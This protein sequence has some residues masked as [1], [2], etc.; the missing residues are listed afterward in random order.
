MPRIRHLK[1]AAVLVT[2]YCSMITFHCTGQQP[3]YLDAKQSIDKRVDDLISQMTLE[4]KVGQI[5]MPCVYMLGNDIPAKNISI[6]KHVD[7]TLLGTGP[8]G[9]FFTLANEVLRDG[10]R[11]QADF[12]NDL[13]KKAVETTRLKIPLMQ[14]EEGMHGFMAPGATIFPQGMGLGAAWNP[15]LIQEIYAAIAEE[16]RSVGV[17]QIQ[18]LQVE[19]NRDPRHGRNQHTV[20]EDTYL[21]SRYAE[22]V[23]RG[24]QGDDI[25]ANNKVI[26]GLG[27]FPGQGQGLN[28]TNRG[29][30]DISE[31]T[32]QE[33][34]LP[35]WKAGINAGALAI[36]ATHPAIDGYPNHGSEKNLTKTLREELGFKGVLISEGSNTGTLIYERVIASEKEAGPIVLKAGVDINITTES[37]YHKDMI[38]NVKEGKVSMELLDRAVRRILRLKFMLGLFENPY[39]DP[40]RAVKIVHS[41]KNQDLALR[42]S[43]ESIVL[44]KNDPFYPANQHISTS[45]HPAAEPDARR[46][47]LQR[48][49]PLLPLSKSLKSIAVIGPNADSEINLLGDYIPKKLLNKTTSVLQAIR[50]KVSPSTKVTYV[51]GCEVLNTKTNTIEE[52]KKAAKQ[53]QIAIVVVGE[54]MRTD[55]ESKDCVDL[56]LTGL[57][58]ELVEAVYETGTPTVVV[59]NSGRPLTIH[60]IT[61][62][63]P[64]IVETWMCGEKGAEAIADVLFGD[65]NPSG[66][67]PITF[68]RHVGQMPFYYNYKPSKYMRREYAYVTMPLSPLYPF[69]HGLS[70]TTFEYSNLKITPK[71][72]GPGAYFQVSLDVK[73]TGAQEGKEV[74]QL[75]IDD[76][77][78]SMVTPIIELKGFE[79]VNLKP[80]EKKSVNFT[81]IPEQLSLL[82]AHMER[83]VEPGAFKVMV[84]S[85]CEDIR[86]EGEFNVIKN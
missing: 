27:C 49:K 24:A 2:V 31:R 61:E 16:A 79:K 81:L 82:D 67:L 40:E 75:Y 64:A 20:S 39:V 43:Q 30:M 69:G 78:S 33:V 12:F 21:C 41:K 36:M 4:E 68:P 59:M 66:K 58:N 74:I 73:N 25:S 9:G 56:E 10:T 18:S 77:I 54:D 14:I 37:G 8:G 38:E 48:V 29:Y 28:G 84:G 45:R 60:W 51:K 72:S 11:Q 62:N 19:P 3:I 63:I 53:A 85:S 65:V 83:V 80:G 46:A 34:Y 1:L 70:Y 22:S 5:N 17:H 23:V 42:A 50:Q 6:Q 26:T 13:Q 35:I 32:L 76:L 15:G 7:G 52:A 55:G 47:S 44:L 57:Q 86:L 71:E